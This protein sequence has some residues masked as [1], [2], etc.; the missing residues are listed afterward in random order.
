GK[1]FENFLDE[2]K[3][4]RS[5]LTPSRLSAIF[6][7]V[8]LM[9]GAIDAS[10]TSLPKAP[11][12]LVDNGTRVDPHAPEGSLEAEDH[13]FGKCAEVLFLRKIS[14]GVK[15]RTETWI[16]PN[17][18]RYSDAWMTSQHRHNQSRSG[19]FGAEHE[20]RPFVEHDTHVLDPPLDTTLRI[21]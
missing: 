17:N 8:A 1:V 10:E 4:V 21:S 9:H 18:L 7:S 5:L 11:H 6:V 14:V 3:V 16:V 13:F 15:I 2:E 19:S 12:D 20:D